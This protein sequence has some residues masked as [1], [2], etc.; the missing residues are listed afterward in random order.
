MKFSNDFVFLLCL[1]DLFL[2]N[3][4]I[5]FHKIIKVI[6]LGMLRDDL[7]FLPPYT[8]NLYEIFLCTFQ[9]QKIFITDNK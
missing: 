4:K 5:R 2:K 9:L 7:G 8:L 1:K 6:F 3:Y